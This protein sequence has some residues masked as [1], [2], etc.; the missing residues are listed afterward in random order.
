MLH[1]HVRCVPPADVL[2]T[3]CPAR[4]RWNTLCFAFSAVQSLAPTPKTPPIVELCYRHAYLESRQKSRH[5]DGDEVREL[6]TAGALLAGDEQSGRR[7]HRRFPVHLLGSL[8]A[9]G[10]LASAVVHNISADGLFVTVP[11]DVPTGTTVQIRLGTEGADYLYT[12]T[13]VRREAGEGVT[14]LG[15]S[16]CCVPLEMRRRRAA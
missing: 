8:K 10:V 13:V 12:G 14:G 9:P 5:L 1:S 2:S 4:S 15:L 6:L 11:A 16:L 7:A 3:T